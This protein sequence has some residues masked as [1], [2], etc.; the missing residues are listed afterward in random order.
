MTKTAVRKKKKIDMVRMVELVRKVKEG[1]QIK[2]DIEAEIKAAKEEIQNTMLE[3]KL[4]EMKV[5]V[6]TVRYQSV[7]SNRFDTAAFKAD[8]KGVYDKYLVSSSTMKFTIS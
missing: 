7:T 4:E 3:F 6:F 8:N 2:K 5:D 1:E